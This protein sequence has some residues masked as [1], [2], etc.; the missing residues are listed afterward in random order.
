ML[1]TF[2]CPRFSNSLK[3]GSASLGTFWGFFSD[4]SAHLSTCGATNSVAILKNSSFILSIVTFVDLGHPRS[5]ALPTS[6]L[7]PIFERTNTAKGSLGALGTNRIRQGRSPH[8]T[9]AGRRSGV[10]GRG[11]TADPCCNHRVSTVCRQQN[12]NGT[13]RPRCP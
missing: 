11:R 3:D 7:T 6:P 13:T 10:T 2:S 8:A 12:Q 1:A 5:I 9:F 4:A